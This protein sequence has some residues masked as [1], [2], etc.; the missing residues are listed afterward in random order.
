MHGCTARWIDQATGE[1]TSE[2][3]RKTRRAVL[4]QHCP[5]SSAE[6]VLAALHD[7]D[8]S[9]EEAADQ[10]EQGALLTVVVHLVGEEGPESA[11]LSVE[12]GGGAANALRCV[13]LCP[14]QVLF[15]LR[16]CWQSSDKETFSFGA[17]LKKSLSFERRI[18]LTGALLHGAGS[19][20]RRTQWKACHRRRSCPM[21]PS[22]RPLG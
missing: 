9:T 20:R 22:P 1:L 13:L 5:M 16:A 11:P 19:S 21:S 2:G 15:L 12:V 14:L 17:L 7:A 4:Q 10:E 6:E 18:S 8:D 3:A